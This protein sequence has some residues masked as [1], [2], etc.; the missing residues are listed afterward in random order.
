MSVSTPAPEILLRAR[1]LGKRFGSIVAVR[2]LDL[3]LHRGEVLGLLG[4]NGAG[5][6]TTL[7]MIL[8]LIAPTAGS[9]EIL[10]RDVTT[11][12]TAATRAVGAIIEAPAFYPYLSGRANLEAIGWALGGV[13]RTRSDEL[14]GL[15]GLADRATSR[16]RTY[17]LGMK[18]RLGIASTLLGD[19]PIVIL[20]EPGNGLDPAGQREIRELIPLLAAQGRAV[21]LAS[22]LLH[23]VDQ[24]CDRV[25]LVRTGELVAPRPVR[26]D[27]VVVPSDAMSN[28][29]HGRRSAHG[30]RHHGVRA[31]GESLAVAL[32]RYRV[33]KH[34][35]IANDGAV[36]GAQVLTRSVLDTTLAFDRPLPGSDRG[37]PVFHSPSRQG[38]RSH[39]GSSVENV[40]IQL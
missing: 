20:D 8:G 16:Y 25:A 10:G 2:A 22:H 21:L 23:E 39:C 33:K 37:F 6:S 24:V 29:V 5:K 28:A 11:D 3:E 30:R 1:G 19:P 17:S 27:P 18:Q 14:L 34:P 9:V 36:A 38:M 31:H 26:R 7:G 15:V 35:A 40:E 13:P 12:R 4:P 32:F